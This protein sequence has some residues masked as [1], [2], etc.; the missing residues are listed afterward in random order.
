MLFLE[1]KT[2]VRSGHINRKD[3]LTDSNPWMTR[4]QINLIALYI[5]CLFNKDL[6]TSNQKVS[7]VSRREVREVESPRKQNFLLIL[8]GRR[9]FI[10]VDW[11]RFDDG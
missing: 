4:L 2:Q 8:D 6:N 10:G 11:H 9:S 7:S 1:Q 5:R 3:I